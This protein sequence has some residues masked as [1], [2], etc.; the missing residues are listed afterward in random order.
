MPYWDYH[1]VKRVLKAAP[2][3]LRLDPTY[4]AL[5]K[6]INKLIDEHDLL[7]MTRS[8]P[9]AMFDVRRELC[10]SEVDD[11][12]NHGYASVGAGE[13]MLRDLLLVHEEA[14]RAEAGRRL[15]EETVRG[16]ERFFLEPLITHALKTTTV[17]NLNTDDLPPWPDQL[18]IFLPRGMVSL[19]Y[20]G[21][22]S[23]TIESVHI[24][25]VPEVEMSDG[26]RRALVKSPVIFYSTIDGGV[27]SYNIAS[28][29]VPPDKDLT[30][31]LDGDYEAVSPALAGGSAT[32]SSGRMI[33]PI[34]INTLLYWKS[35]NEDILEQINPQ[36]EKVR[37]RMLRCKKSKK[38][39]KIKKQ[40]RSI[41]EDRYCV[42]GSKLEILRRRK[43]IEVP[44]AQDMSS[45]EEGEKTGASVVQHWTRGHFK[46]QPCGP[47]RSLRKLIFVSDY[48]KGT[49]PPPEKVGYSVRS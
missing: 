7:N 34:L 14:F 37:A 39:D 42:L 2:N 16:G 12:V 19:L 47:R 35:Q 21:H 20:E 33:F 23:I 30:C 43:N 6:R 10:V 9:L 17:K 31:L 40:L 32:W 25:G 29:A 45:S 24:I 15:Y 22:Q 46:W 27:T 13:D 1:K 26:G 38:R 8:D 44:F 18:S 41:P 49:L 4:R 36:Y 11:I 48:Q 3:A 5:A 28:I